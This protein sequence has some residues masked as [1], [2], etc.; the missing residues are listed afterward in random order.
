MCREEISLAP[1]AK[2]SKLLL[3]S[4]GK[5]KCGQTST[6]GSLKGEG[7]PAGSQHI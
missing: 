3:G 2:K 1:K 5:K 6:K 7:A 4:Q